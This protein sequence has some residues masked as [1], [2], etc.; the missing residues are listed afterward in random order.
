MTDLQ[1]HQQQPEKP[2]LQSQESQPPQEPQEPR[3][4]GEY[5]MPEEAKQDELQAVLAE[6]EATKP[7]AKDL[8]D[9]TQERIDERPQIRGR[10]A[11]LASRWR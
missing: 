6:T 11:A 7:F 1:Q 5:R 4:Q 9:M 10:V 8:D 3:S 2:P